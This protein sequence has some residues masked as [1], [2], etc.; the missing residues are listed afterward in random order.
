M[1]TPIRSL[2]RG[3]RKGA[4]AV[5]AVLATVGLAAAPVGAAPPYDFQADAGAI[6][7]ESLGTLPDFELDLV[8]VTT[9]SPPFVGPYFNLDLQVGPAIFGTAQT[10]VV[11]GEGVMYFED[12]A[13]NEYGV[14]LGPADPAVVIGADVSGTISVNDPGPHDLTQNLWLT[15]QVYEIAPTCD[16]LE[17]V[18]SIVLV[19]DDTYT[20]P[21]TGGYDGTIHPT[22][23][24]EITGL[25]GTG[26]A[27][28]YGACDPDMAASFQGAE[29]T[30]DGFDL[31][32][33]P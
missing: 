6:T 16:D 8:T 15:F 12:G 19:F 33:V 18:C 25:S 29:V 26:V 1:T 4:A 9:C 23:V 2:R 27:V 28:T 13:S 24:T 3:A 20:D 7:L 10:Q 14:V 21:F 11:G 31:T 22:G 5:V 32:Y 17:L 30:F